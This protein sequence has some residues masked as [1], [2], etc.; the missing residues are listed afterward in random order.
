M[1]VALKGFISAHYNV[2]HLAEESRVFVLE[3]SDSVSL[4]IN[5]LFVSR[6]AIPGSCL[7]LVMERALKELDEIPAYREIQTPNIS[8]IMGC[9]IKYSKKWAK[10]PRLISALAERIH[11]VFLYNQCNWEREL[12]KYWGESFCGVSFE[13][14]ALRIQRLAFRLKQFDLDSICFL[15]ERIREARHIYHLTEKSHFRRTVLAQNINDLKSKLD[16]SICERRRIIR[17]SSSLIEERYA[18]R[19]LLAIIDTIR[20]VNTFERSFL[21]LPTQLFKKA[22][23]FLNRLPGVAIFSQKNEPGLAEYDSIPR[24][25]SDH[26]EIIAMSGELKDCNTFLLAEFHYCST[27]EAV[28]QMFVSSFATPGSYLLVEGRKALEREVL[29]PYNSDIKKMVRSTISFDDVIGWDSENLYRNV[30]APQDVDDVVLIVH[31][32]QVKRIKAQFL[33]NNYT[34]LLKERDFNW[35]NEMLLICESKLGG[36]D[37]D[38][39]Y[40]FI[41]QIVLKANE[42]RQFT[43]KKINPIILDLFCKARF[44]DMRS[45]NEKLYKKLLYYLNRRLELLTNHTAHDLFFPS[46]TLSM[47][48]S[49]D[50]IRMRLDETSRC[51]LVAGA[52]HLEEGIGWNKMSLLEKARESLKPLY[53][54]IRK[55]PGIAVLKPK[56]LRAEYLKNDFEWTYGTAGTTIV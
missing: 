56:V 6:F 55:H 26:Y 24:A 1:D 19:R 34:S 21:F 17:E 7:L 20:R 2:D 51:F 9:D 42:I 49:I 14:A 52:A 35:E 29:A 45:D 12:I 27:C 10:I 48:E 44:K 40:E 50:S 32:N 47:I 43:L 31:A 16:E 8:M 53:D 18:D 28:N 5:D 11:N 33:G 15:Q 41:R 37:T 54:Y 4:K 36:Y 13:S 23:P 39:Q 22:F 30:F 3:E 25:I 46:R 38:N